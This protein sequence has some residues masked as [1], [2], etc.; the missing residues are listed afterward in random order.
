MRSQPAN[1]LLKCRRTKLYHRLERPCAESASLARPP[2]SKMGDRAARSRRACADID[3]VHGRLKQTRFRSPREDVT[4]ARRWSSETASEPQEVDL[5]SLCGSGKYSLNVAAASGVDETAVGDRRFTV[6]LGRASRSKGSPCP[7][8]DADGH[9]LV[10]MGRNVRGARPLGVRG[11]PLRLPTGL[12]GQH[13]YVRP[14]LPLPLVP[15]QPAVDELAPTVC[16]AVEP[17]WVQD[18]LGR[19][20][21]GGHVALRRLAVRGSAAGSPVVR[22]IRR[23]G[24]GIGRNGTGLV[25][26][27]GPHSQRRRRDALCA[28]RSGSRDNRVRAAPVLRAGARSG[29]GS[30]RTRGGKVRAAT[31]ER[32]TRSR[33]GAPERT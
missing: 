31:A 29:A 19:G 7:V 11:N 20:V 26:S 23:T 32:P 12:S 27:G 25:R 21:V 17:R 4:G 3:R 6:R 24:R 5:S 8:L 18:F 28:K 14:H 16:A 30:A 13:L 22:R 2:D 1:L 33:G 9:P 15:T 10:C